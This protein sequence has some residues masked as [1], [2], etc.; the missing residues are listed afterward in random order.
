MY[1]LRFFMIGKNTPGYVLKRY[2]GSNFMQL[3]LKEKIIHI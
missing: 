3:D 1:E 2:L